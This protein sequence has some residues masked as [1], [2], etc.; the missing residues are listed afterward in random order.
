MSSKVSLNALWW[1]LVFIAAIATYSTVMVLSIGQSIWFDEG[2]SILLAKSS[3]SDLFALTA[4]DA[5]PP[6]YYA[7][8]KVWGDL[9]GFSEFALRSLSAV[10]VSGAVVTIAVLL[11]KL[12]S[13]KVALLTLPILLF[14]PFLLRYGYEV[15]MYALATLI[16]VVATYVLVIASKNQRWWLW[17]LYAALV[18]LGMYTLYM[19]AIVWIAHVI[20]LLS[21]SIKKPRQPFLQWRWLYAYIAAVLLFSPYIATFFYQLTHSALPGIGAAVTLTRL[22]DIAAVLLTFT[23]EWQLSALLSVLIITALGLAIWVGVKVHKQLSKQ[24][25]QYYTLLVLLAATPVV[26]YTLTS[27]VS[28]QQI[29]VNRYLAHVAIYMYALLGVTVALGVI[30]RDKLKAKRAVP[31]LAYV[32]VL[33]V[34]SIGVIQLHKVGNF[35]FERV[36]SPQTQHI[37][38][39]IECSDETTIIAD[40]PYT[41]I[42]SV[43]YFDGCDIRF[44]SEKDVEKKGGYAML[45]QSA[46]RVSSPADVSAQMLVVLGWDGDSSDFQ[47]DDR[48]ELV[49][50]VIMDKQRAETYRLI[51]E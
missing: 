10:L 37:R 39:S 34:L 45:H 21:Q 13:P 47:P 36:Q 42:D 48:Y 22:G 9:F 26:F 29:F 11:R 31:L 5:H 2:Y 50:T 32:A 14:G 12:F 23:S 8:L 7:L 17:A 44:F 3:W 41:Y 40:D 35:I 20:W 28:S 4:V 46:S 18:A 51:A 49:S 43:F 15:R 38:D 30:H 24:E 33:V 16:G 19:M 27:I 6:F 25:K 1:P